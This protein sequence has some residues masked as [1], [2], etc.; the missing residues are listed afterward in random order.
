MKTIHKLVFPLWL[1]ATCFALVALVPVA[2]AQQAQQVAV[3][4]DY[5]AKLEFINEQTAAQHER[6]AGLATACAAM[7]DKI[8]AASAKCTTDVCVV[9]LA[10]EVGLLKCAAASAPE[11]VAARAIAVPEPP[12]PPAPPPTTGERIMSGLGWVGGKLIDG[13]FGSVP[14]LAQLK[15][16]LETSKNTTLLGV[17]QSNNALGA[18]QST[19][20][21]MTMFGNNLAAV[22]TNGFNSNVAINAAAGNT[23]TNIAIAGFGATRELGLKP[24][25][26]ITG[27]GNNLINGNANTTQSGSNNRQASPGPCQPTATVTTPAPATTVT[28]PTATGTVT[29][30]PAPVTTVTSD[31]AK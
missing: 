11:V 26:V 21:V 12:A 20:G 30:T 7:A 17:T 16:G 19:N 23:A 24:T 18:T 1:L 8:M 22:A 25:T 10:R 28:G 9:F 13:V 5:Q 3:K 15:L 4:S 6:E 29:S 14:A 27:D 2:Q 31:C